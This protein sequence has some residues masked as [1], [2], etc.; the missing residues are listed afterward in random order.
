MA[1]RAAGFASISAQEAGR[2]DITV[3]GIEHVQFAQPDARRLTELAMSEAAA[4]R[5]RPVIGQTFPLEQAAD[6]HRVIEARDAVGK[7]LLVI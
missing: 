2:R 3:H 7:T 6:A 1:R 5:I 4:G